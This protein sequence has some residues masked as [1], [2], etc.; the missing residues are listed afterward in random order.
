MNYKD[1]RARLDKRALVAWMILLGIIIATEIG[2]TVVIPMWREYFYNVLQLKNI[3][4]FYPALGWFAALMIGMGT[5]QGLKS[6]TGYRISFI[7]RE[8]ITKTLFRNWLASDRTA[9]NYT[10]ALTESIRN[11]TELYLE[12]VVE[13]VISAAI[14]VILV[15]SNLHSVPIITASLIYTLSM[16]ALA[17]AFNKP[18]VRTDADAQKAEGAFREAISD[19]FSGK[20]DY[21]YSDKW[22]EVAK[23][24][25]TYIKVQMNFTLFSRVKGS[26]ASLIPYILLSSSFFAGTITLGEFMAGVATF[27]L[28]VVN[29]TIL[30]ALYQKLTRA[31]ASKSITKEFA[32]YVAKE[33][34]ND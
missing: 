20:N 4:E 29:A 17:A 22:A 9:P 5:V 18:L 28:L 6:W 14:V 19:I 2:L 1:I 3:A 24:Y 34:N 32:T 31:R 27:E 13:V 15:L 30:M 33:R 26:L 25:Y 8:A 16:S 12:I 23:T 11:S 21:T 10:Q 7:V